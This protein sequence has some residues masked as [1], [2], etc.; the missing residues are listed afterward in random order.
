M[1]LCHLHNLVNARLGKEE[2]DCSANLAGVYDCGCG[3]DTPVEG[4]DI[5]T[6]KK[7]AVGRG[8]A[9]RREEV[10]EAEEEEED[11]RRD[12]LTGAQLVGG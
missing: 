5:G 11:I 1:H 2:F 12:P 3:D 9:R 10:E 6:G 8:A 7:H 4:G